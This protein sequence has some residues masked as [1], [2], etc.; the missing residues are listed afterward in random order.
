LFLLLFAAAVRVH[1]QTERQREGTIPF[2]I[3]AAESV[4]DK[5]G[6]LRRK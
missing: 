4:C 5:S 6:R 2:G 1:N 3:G